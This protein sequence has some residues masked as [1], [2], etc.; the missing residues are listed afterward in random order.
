MWPANGV[1]VLEAAKDLAGPRTLI[2]TLTHFH[3]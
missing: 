2:L 1:R 3:P